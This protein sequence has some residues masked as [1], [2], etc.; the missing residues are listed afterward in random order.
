MKKGVSSQNRETGMVGRGTGMLNLWGEVLEEKVKRLSVFSA[1]QCPVLEGKEM[2]AEKG[3]E[4][5]S[6]GLK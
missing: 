5:N 3:T 2:G 6:E 1:I 4:E